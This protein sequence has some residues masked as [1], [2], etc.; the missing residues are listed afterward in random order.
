MSPNLPFTRRKSPKFR[1]GCN[2][3]PIIERLRCVVFSAYIRNYLFFQDLRGLES[4]RLCRVYRKV[5][6]LK[7]LN[8]LIQSMK[9]DSLLKLMVQLLLF[10]ALIIEIE[11][12]SRKFSVFLQSS[13]RYTSIETSSN[14][15]VLIQD[16]PNTIGSS[17][18]VSQ[19]RLQ[20]Q[21]TLKEFLL[22]S[23][24]R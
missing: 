23:R 18:F 16:L 4:Q 15:I 20:L 5:S 11:S 1:T 12:L 13:Q 6:D 9:I 19:A 8:G 21:T 10:Q 14:Q 22:S 2:I 3:F 7:S 24:V 17:S